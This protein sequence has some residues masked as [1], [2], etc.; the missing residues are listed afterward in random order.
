M[1]NEYRFNRNHG[2]LEIE[3][4]CISCPTRDEV[5]SKVLENYPHT[6]ISTIP[7]Q[8]YIQHRFEQ[9]HRYGFFSFI[10]SYPWQK[11]VENK[12][13]SNKVTKIV[14]CSKYLFDLSPKGLKLYNKLSGNKLT[15]AW[16]IKRD[17]IHLIEVIEKL[18]KEANHR[19]N[20][21]SKITNQL[22]IVSIP[23]NVDWVLI[24]NDFCAEYIAEKH[25][26]WN[27]RG[28]E[29]KDYE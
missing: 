27:F 8:D 29:I 19:T 20:K 16:G 11:N 7:C 9:W 22:H 10:M 14:V 18:G 12:E 4:K 15:N 17:D 13:K 6:D 5:I 2:A 28:E 23:A 1:N 3:V 21:Y 24:Q 26:A 25:R